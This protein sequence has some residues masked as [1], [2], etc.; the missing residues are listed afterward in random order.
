MSTSWTLAFNLFISGLISQNRISLEEPS[1]ECCSNIPRRAEKI[2]VTIEEKEVD[3][4]MFCLLSVADN[5]PGIAENLQGRI[6]ESFITG[7]NDPSFSTK[8][9]IGLRIV[10]NTMD[11]HHGKVLLNSAPAKAPSL[12]FIFRWGASILKKMYINWLMIPV[13]NRRRKHSLPR[14]RFVKR[15]PPNQARNCWSLKITMR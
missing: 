6:F 7:E 3:G 8:V 15:H 4:K 11:L 10:K 5:G 12:S 13:M 1:F 14:K 9:G 2:R